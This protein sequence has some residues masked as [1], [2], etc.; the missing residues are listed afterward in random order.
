MKENVVYGGQHHMIMEIW[1]R[2]GGK[3]HMIMERPAA[4]RSSGSAGD[5]VLT[6][7]FR[8]VKLHH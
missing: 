3:V 2:S 7:R 8:A 4:L 1:L 6:G 5:P